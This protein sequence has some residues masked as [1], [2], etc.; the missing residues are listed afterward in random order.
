MKDAT[1]LEL[2]NVAF[3]AHA[4]AGKT[5]LVEACLFE[6]GVTTRLGRVSDGTT[7]TDYEPEE[8]RR[9]MTISTALAVCETAGYKLNL[10][11]LP[12]IADFFG[13]VRTVLSAVDGA[14]LVLRATTGI[15]VE[16]ERAWKRLKELNLPR[17]LFVNKMDRENGDYFAVLEQCRKKFGN[18]A[19]PL[20]MPIGAESGFRGVIDLVENKAYTYSGKVGAKAYQE[21][22]IPA[23]L[24]DEA[25][26]LRQIL[27][28]SA[29]EQD[30]ELMNTYLEGGE[31]TTEALKEAL[32]KGVQS[33]SLY[34]V[35][36]GGALKNM[37]THLLL[38]AIQSYLPGPGVRPMPI[39]VPEGALCAQVFK[40]TADPFVG[41]LSYVRVYSGELKPDLTVQK[42][43]SG[44]L[45]KIGHI[46]TLKGKQ[47]LPLSVLRAGDIGVLPKMLDLKTGDTLCNKGAGFDLEM[48]Q[49]LTPQFSLRMEVKKGEEDKVMG[50]L[51]KLMDEDGALRITKDTENQQMLVTGMGELHL[52][53]VME[54]LKRKFGLE[55]Q[56]Q[57]PKIP[58][59]ETIKGKVKVEGKHK[60]QS[61]GHGQFGH[62]WL[63]IEPSTEVLEFKEQVFGGAVPKQ[64][65]PA[66]EKGVH[67]AMKAGVLAGYPLTG[68]KVT[69]VDGS[70]HSVDSSE[71]AFK[72]AAA[73]AL[74]KGAQLAKPVL[75]EPIYQVEVT[76]PDKFVGDV[77]S[78]LNGKGGHILGTEPEE[79]GWSKIT[80][81]VP[82]GELFRYAVEL[83]A[84]THGR[85]SYEKQFD[86][87]AEVAPKKAEVIMAEA[88][89]A[90]AKAAPVHA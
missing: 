10:L 71:I 57:S 62:V 69:L 48:A 33:A 75:L 39:V 79:E 9:K 46:F 8:I 85:G 55:V 60:K 20:V 21:E 86:H 38:E 59:R 51:T 63:E 67:E 42:G 40:T 61:G 17:L 35:L 84:L 15:E 34:P 66:V 24:A 11:D 5:S 78:D 81:Q 72:T 45:E 6:A 82:Y 47:Q 14:V 73:M 27:V 3:V 80:A 4:G 29:V 64:Y 87:Y 16:T 23:E 49:G 74:K 36:C 52:E 50:A 32:R 43:T 44:K 25:A 28:E 41:R 70:Y 31:V 90:A 2:R 1:D 56:L 89:T 76:T 88:K 19:V 77:V 58:Y 22:S 68:L 65:F 30:D 18:S 83:R 7:V 37:G 12:G 26:R 13:E 53:I 54:K